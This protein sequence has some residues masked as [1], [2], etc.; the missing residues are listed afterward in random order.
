[1]AL[2]WAQPAA[3]E[4]TQTLAALGLK[5][6]SEFLPETA[7]VCFGTILSASENDLIFRLARWNDFTNQTEVIM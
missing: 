2:I 5:I 7:L 1:M 6:F 3:S 4:S